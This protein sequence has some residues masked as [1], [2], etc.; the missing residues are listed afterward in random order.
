MKVKSIKPFIAYLTLGQFNLL[1]ENR[2]CWGKK[3]VFKDLVFEVYG[4]FSLVLWFG[5]VYK[6]GSCA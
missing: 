3:K 1:L 4:L 2:F 6:I 5:L